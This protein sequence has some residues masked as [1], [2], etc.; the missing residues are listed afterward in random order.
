VKVHPQT[1]DSTSRAI[2][3]NSGELEAMLCTAALLAA[4][5][6][7]RDLPPAGHYSALPRCLRTYE[8]IQSRAYHIFL[9]RGGTHGHDVEDWIRAQR[10]LLK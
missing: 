2:I 10:E 4:L 9:E 3:P 1:S 6:R 7:A 5:R 8:E